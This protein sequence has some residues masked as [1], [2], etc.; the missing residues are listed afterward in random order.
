M[1]ARAIT[2]MEESPRKMGACLGFVVAC[3]KFFRD[4]PLSSGRLDVK[5]VCDGVKS[6]CYLN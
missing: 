3:N 2:E 1:H 5:A 6:Q 4:D